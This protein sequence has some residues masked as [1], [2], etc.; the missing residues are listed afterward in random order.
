MAIISKDLGEPG[1][2]LRKTRVLN[3]DTNVYLD[4]W[5]R[6]LSG[7]TV[8]RQLKLSSVR[9][10]EDFGNYVYFRVE[11]TSIFANNE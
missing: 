4:I 10:Y 9:R 5:I 2:D 8:L 7:G 11:K 6:D 1:Y 3:F